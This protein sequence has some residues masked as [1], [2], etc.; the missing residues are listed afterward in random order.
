MM[1]STILRKKLTPRMIIAT[2]LILLF[3]PLYIP[4]GFPIIVSKMTTGYYDTIQALGPNSKVIIGF[5]TAPRNYM[6]SGFAGIHT[7]NQIY[8]R[9]AK[10]VAVAPSAVCIIPG[11]QILS[12]EF[13]NK[14]IKYGTDIVFLGLAPEKATFEYMIKDFWGL[15]ATDYFG[16]VI[17]DMPIY[18]TLGVSK[19]TD[20]DLIICL[21]IAGDEQFIRVWAV[22]LGIP[23]LYVAD[24]GGASSA[25]AWYPNPIKSL[26][27]GVAGTA[28]YEK[29][30]GVKYKATGLTDIMSLELSFFLILMIYGTINV[31]RAKIKMKG[32]K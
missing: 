16:D 28:E 15:F 3:F 23:A 29:M 9:G 2:V 25:F 7:I 10:M 26:L 14:D 12:D 27:F 30:L 4:I 6:D 22:A 24:P 20:F 8:S 1:L 31:I 5:S 18:K 11:L 21:G 32:V 19:V 13:I 17:A